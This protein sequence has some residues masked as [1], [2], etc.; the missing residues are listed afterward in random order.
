LKLFFTFDDGHPDDFRLIRLF[1]KYKL[2]LMLFIPRYNNENTVISKEDI[3]NIKSEIIEIGSH[4]YN[5]TRL[6]IIDKKIIYYELLNGKKY[7]EDILSKP[8]DH[9]CFPGGQFN[10][11]SMKIAKD[12]FSTIRTAETMCLIH[13]K[14][15]IN[16]FFHFFNRQKKS[17][18]FNS[19]RNNNLN[20]GVLNC[21]YYSSSYFDF[22]KKYIS[23]SSL[24]N[25]ND[26][27]VIWGHSWE[28]TKYNLW[29]ELDDLLNFIFLN[30]SSEVYKYSEI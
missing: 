14:P 25:N 30:H 16:T 26:E 21:L 6:N 15:I 8:I 19:L 5:H 18:L 3:R 23:Y 28:L 12:L 29:Q 4:T 9:F 2:P 22:I 10:N 24:H 13:N 1:E 11:S 20:F 27:I 7:L 17:L